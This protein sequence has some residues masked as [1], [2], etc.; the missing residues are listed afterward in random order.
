METN[1]YEDFGTLSFFSINSELHKKGSRLAHGNKIIPQMRLYCVYLIAIL[2]LS[3]L[4]SGEWV[5]RGEADDERLIEV[6][7]AVKHQNLDLLEDYL[8]E[9]SNPSS[10]F[11]GYFLSK[12]ELDDLL[13]P[14][15]ES[16]EKVVQW[17][18]DNGVEEKNIQMTKSGEFISSI[19]P[20][21]HAEKLLSTDLYEYEHTHS[22]S[23]VI[24]PAKRSQLP[25]HVTPHVD[26]VSPTHSFPS[27][28]QTFLKPK[29]FRTLEAN[30]LL[31]SDEDQGITPRWLREFY[32][33]DEGH[34]FGKSE[35]NRQAVA[36]FLEQYYDPVDLNLFFKRFN[37]DS[38]MNLSSVQVFGP[39]NSSNPGIEA[40]MDIQFIMSLADNVTTQFWSTP[41]RMPGNVENEPFLKW[42]VN[43]ANTSDEEIPYVI[44]VR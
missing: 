7:V 3:C 8:L 39:N 31:M 13:A 35:K 44:S 36:Q 26:L 33:I 2:A 23:K 6:I 16:I 9:I 41:G 32:G 22:K 40:S 38:P 37:N 27:E 29:K 12:N 18:V 4:S 14:S 24:R 11:Y 19:L 17:M 42:L 1:E 15:D 5:N 21:G 34:R 20:V 28:L 43:L 30:D 25:N 10:D